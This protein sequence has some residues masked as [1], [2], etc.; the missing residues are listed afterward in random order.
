[1]SELHNSQENASSNRTSFP[2]VLFPSQHVG[3]FIDSVLTFLDY[4]KKLA[5]NW[6]ETL[7]LF[8]ESV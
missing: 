3:A 5:S 4:L 7:Y 6:V 1:M 8:Q 2:C